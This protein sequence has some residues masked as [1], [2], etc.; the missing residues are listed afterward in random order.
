MP[1]VK[2][3]RILKG[4]NTNVGV[5]RP[6]KHHLIMSLVMGVMSQTSLCPTDDRRGISP[7]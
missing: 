1:E 4:E 2:E 3:D 5:A 6:G 7:L